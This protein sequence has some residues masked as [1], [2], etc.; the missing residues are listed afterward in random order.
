MLKDNMAN[1]D[2]AF[3]GVARLIATPM[4]KLDQSHMMVYG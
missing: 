4:M 1:K 3:I 2:N